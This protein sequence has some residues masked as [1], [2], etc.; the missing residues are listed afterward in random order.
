MSKILLLGGC[1]VDYIATSTA[2]LIMKSS[3]IG[4]VSISFGGVMRNVVEN[5]A[6]LG[7]EC[8][9]LTAIG[10]DAYGKKMKN[11]LEK[12]LKVHLL[13]PKTN[14]KTS[15]YLCINDSNNDM[16]VALNDMEIM[17]DLNAQFL[18]TNKNLIDSFEKIVIDS[19]LNEEA[20]EFLFKNFKD[21][22]IYCE[23]ISAEKVIKYR[24]YLKNIYLLKCNFYEASALINKNLPIKEIIEEIKNSGV[25]NCVITQGAE[26]VFYLDNG[27]ISSYKVNKISKIN[28][29]TTGCGD[30]MFAGII[31]SLLDN[32]S[33]K[34]A[35]EFGNKLSVLTLETT[36]AVNKFVGKVKNYK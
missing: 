23:G 25:K 19:N 31:D 17:D 24:P 21:K 15:S 10:N 13:M 6:R 22:K 14:K 1:N 18:K 4:K 20:L 3:N 28:G 7:N 34:E 35:I 29:N 26:D 12:T 5:L 11:E 9:F 2:P 27:E 36:S 16:A 8:Y 33:L 32:K 30:A